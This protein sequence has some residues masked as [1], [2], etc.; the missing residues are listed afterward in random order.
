M[1]ISPADIVS[2]SVAV[3]GCVLGIVNFAIDI[4][5]RR[6]RLKVSL[7]WIFLWN[8]EYGIC[9]AVAVKLMNTG[10]VPVTIG[11]IG[12]GVKGGQFIGVEAITVE[13]G[14]VPERIEPGESL[15][16]RIPRDTFRKCPI[17]DLRRVFVQLPCEEQF[18][19]GSIRDF[20]KAVATRPYD[21]VEE[22]GFPVEKSILAPAD[23][24]PDA[25]RQIMENCASA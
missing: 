21:Q 22:R 7:R 13:G 2:L 5:R 15:V 1:E 8:H 10:E 14:R 24:T 9:K 12:C 18:F 16:V 3:I 19:G 25:E 23:C 11:L 20:A 17:K 4:L 6:R